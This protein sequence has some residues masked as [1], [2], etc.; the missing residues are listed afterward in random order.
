VGGDPRLGTQLAGYV[1]E[2]LVGRGGMG[3]VYL[4]QDL[5]LNRRIALKILAPEFSRDERFRARFVRESRVAA[6]IEH[7][8]IV[9]IYEAGEADGELFIAMRYVGGSD[10]EELIRR[11]GP[12]GPS[13]VSSIVSQTAS[14]LDAAH[15]QGLVHRDV[16]PANLLLAPKGTEHEEDHVYVSDFGITKRLDTQGSTASTGRMLGSLDFIAPEQIEGAPVDRRAD[17]YSLGC[18]LYQCLTATVPFPRDSEMAVMW[19]HVHEDPPVPSS[20]RPDL[21]LE[22]DAVVARAMAKRPVD[23]FDTAGRLA[24]A[25]RQAL[26]ATSRSS[27]TI[28][29]EPS[30]DHGGHRWRMRP[31]V[32]LALALLPIAVVG[33]VLGSVL[34]RGGRRPQTGGSPLPRGTSSP[35]TN[36]SPPPPPITSATFQRIDAGSTTLSSNIV[37]APAHARAIAAGEGRI[38]SLTPNGVYE[39]NPANHQSLRV[40]SVTSATDVAVGGGDVFVSVRTPAG[41][42]KVVKID[43]ATRKVVFRYSSP[44]PIDAV[45]AGPEHVWALDDAAGTVTE[46]S[47]SRLVPMGT[48]DVSPGTSD[49]AINEFV[50]VLNEQNGELQQIAPRQGRRGHTT[51]IP[52]RVSAVGAGDA[53]VW[54][55][56]GPAGRVI[57]IDTTSAAMTGAAIQFGEPATEITDAG[58]WVWVASGRTLEGINPVSHARRTVPMPARIVAM[59]ADNSLLLKPAPRAVWVLLAKPQS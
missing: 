4:A 35:I 38:W 23:R 25:A 49:L 43:P 39:T 13:R 40:P 1:I 29:A 45:V 52:E 15:D 59:A 31:R 51:S 9:P 11:T 19:A 8:N 47:A 32:L 34:T 55:L 12:L 36:T 14:A 37:P 30:P 17:V 3:V 7:P 50:W 28:V 6:A 53:G 5:R 16:K 42:G 18:V 44:S 41:G 57:P 21:P 20:L 2:S 26:E 56:D 54:V 58:T 33:V 48:L 24:G 22:I 27:R 46:L 10:L